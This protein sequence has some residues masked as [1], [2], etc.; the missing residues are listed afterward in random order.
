METL[1][2][3]VT[4]I[5]PSEYFLQYSYTI[6]LWNPKKGSLIKSYAG[7]HNREVLDIAIFNENDKF[8]SCGGDK[9]FYIWDVLSGKYIRKF[10]A[11]TNKIN[12][13]CLNHF[14]NVIATG[15]FDNSVK[16]WDLMSRDYRPIQVLDDFRDSITKIMITDDSIIASSVDGILRTYDIRMGKLVRDNIEAPINS[17]DIGEDKKFVAVSCLN[18]TTKLYDLST[19][20]TIADYKGHHKSDNYHGSVKFSKDN[21]YLVQASEDN[22]IVLYDIVTKEP[23]NILRGHLR[24][25]VSIDRHPVEPNKYISGS[26]DGYIKK[27]YQIFLRSMYLFFLSDFKNKILTVTLLIRT[28]KES[29]IKNFAQVEAVMRQLKVKFDGKLINQIM[30]E[31][32][33]AA[34]RLL[35][36]IKL[37]IM[38]DN[39]QEFNIQANTKTITGLDKHT[40]DRR[41]EEVMQLKTTLPTLNKFQTMNRSKK[42]ESIE[43]TL[44]K[45]EHTKKQQD[46]YAYKSQKDEE[47]LINKLYQDQRQMSMNKMKENQQ[48]MKDWEK[49][50]RKNWGQNQQKRSDAIARQ[51]YFEDL[52]VKAFK[53]KLGKEL[54]EATKD[55]AGGINEFEMNLQKLGIEKNTNIEDAIKRM[56]E[57]KGIPPGQ[58]Q[59]FSYAATMNKIKENKNLQDFAAKERDRRRRK[60]IVDQARTQN[61]LDKKKNEEQLIQ[62]IMKKQAE[63]QQFAYLEWRNQQCKQ[64]IIKNREEKAFGVEEKKKAQ[65]QELERKR[66]EEHAAMIE[67]HRKNIQDQKKYYQQ[68]RRE[69][70]LKRRMLNIEVCSE[71]MD[72]I[73]DV[74]NQTFDQQQKNGIKKLDKPTWREWMNIFV[75]NKLVSSVVGDHHHGFS[76]GLTDDD[77]TRDQYSDPLQDPTKNLE[78]ILDEMKFDPAYEDL[79]QYLS[80][81]GIFN[82]NQGD[83]APY[84]NQMLDLNSFDF[85]FKFLDSLIPPHNPE[86]GRNLKQI[87]SS[88]WQTEQ[89]DNL[90]ESKLEETIGIPHHLPLKLCIL[91]K[92][93]GGKR[94]VAK[95]I[96]EL[97]NNK[98]KVFKM[99]DLIKEVYEYVSP[100][101]QAVEV[102]KSKKAPAKKVEEAA[103]IDAYAGMDTKDYK[104]I[105]NQV[106]AIFGENFDFA[107]LN[108]SGAPDLVSMIQDDSLLIRLFIQKL[109]LSFPQDKPEQVKIEEIKL[110]I[111]KEKEILEQLA[112]LEQQNAAVGG[113]QDKKGKAPPAKGKNAGSNEDQLRQDLE[114]IQKIQ[115][116]GWILLDFPR[117]LSQA[118]LMEKLMTGFQS[119]TD[120]PKN[121]DLVAFEQWSKIASASTS[122]AD[123][124]SDLPKIYQSASDAVIFLDTPSDECFR[125]SQNRKIDP[126]TGTVYHLE[127]NP[128]P[129]NDNKL[130]DRLQEYSDPDADSNKMNNHHQVYDDNQQLLKT[131]VNGFGL[132][133][134]NIEPVNALI[135]VGITHGQKKQDVWEKVSKELQ[136]VLGFK[137]AQYDK[138]KLQVMQAEEQNQILLDQQKLLEQQQQEQLN[139]SNVIEQSPRVQNNDQNQLDASPQQQFELA[140]SRTRSQR[141]MQSQQSKRFKSEKSIVQPMTNEE[142]RDYW[143]TF[144]QSYY[145]E[146]LTVFKVIRRQRDLILEGLNDMQTRF[147]DFLQRTD[148]KVQKVHEFIESF[149]KF[150]D[151]FPDLREDEQTKEELLKRVDTLNND[152]WAIVEQRKDDAIAEHAKLIDNGWIDI[153][154]KKLIKN[155]T[156]VVQNEVNKYL[157][158]YA[159]LVG[160][161]SPMQIRVERYFNDA[162]D[163]GLAAI[164]QHKKSPILHQISKLI[165]KDIQQSLIDHQ[166]LDSDVRQQLKIESDNLIFRLNMI[167]TWITV[168]L[169]DFYYFSQEVYNTMDDWISIAVLEEN[170]AIKSVVDKLQNG[171]FEQQL[172]LDYHQFNVSA[173]DLYS[174]IQTVDYQPNKSIMLPSQ[175]G[176]TQHFKIEHLEI[177]YKDFRQYAFDR[178]LDGQTFIHII[179]LSLKENR[180]PGSWRCL[181]FSSFNNILRRYTVKPLGMDDDYS[182]PI[183]SSRD[184]DGLAQVERQFVDWKKI[185]TMFILLQTN[186][187]DDQESLNEYGEQLRELANERGEISQEDFLKAEAWFE[188]V[189]ALPDIRVEQ[190]LMGDEDDEDYDPNLMSQ[191][192]TD[193]TRLS[194]IKSLIF[195]THQNNTRKV[196]V[197]EYIHIL[198]EIQAIAYGTTCYQGLFQY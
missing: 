193:Y 147:I 81:T 47:E 76:Q 138:K 112:E 83:H 53:D 69:E 173:L 143:Q 170:N 163:S 55:M 197:N 190:Q 160:F 187:G 44:L 25:V 174:K 41:F 70:K 91:G 188:N 14:Q 123:S 125:R 87:L 181:E 88:L 92:K 82:L 80:V 75:D 110:N 152:L 130:K 52:E 43:K 105:G 154:L 120:L 145:K 24:P 9:T 128:P 129:E 103:P 124:S 175:N 16:L 6:Q 67:S 66:N 59:N 109:K 51:Q 86:L 90:E 116:E 149:N 100:K 118:K 40:L 150:S 3:Q 139:N 114:L 127:D 4:L 78:S 177:L 140:P 58:I 108:N 28:N 153:E 18:S 176:L 148:A 2:C 65:M 102:D 94:T 164:N 23:L 12:A 61:N 191:V 185:L 135:E 89:P 99:D 133:E 37:G 7:V 196:N 45:F 132:E 151:E 15:S 184:Q 21:S 157:A 68:V 156:T 57:K 29:K 136:R 115:P 73:L 56:E 38:K 182:K 194:R 142:K 189:Q 71:V 134:D 64:L 60:M 168:K 137:Q 186:M 42:L 26:A 195:N 1:L 30:N 111:Q 62:K 54:D 46:D 33:G 50:G 49:E 31:E 72:L 95:Q 107:T 106:K 141:E 126:T 113:A 74:A 27:T 96:Q 131:W 198:K 165:L 169:M 104:D 8:A 158:F 20:E 93:Y 13:I 34:L 144:E 48:F 63:E 155:A 178:Y 79:L 172:R 84:W 101:P 171:I 22:N 183:Y 17:F 167:Q 146:C 10:I 5:E 35:Y 121:Q 97:Y 11:H 180:V 179:V 122:E 117:T 19:G 98:V 36:Q 119:M 159:L 162:V 39:P 192:M 32:R 85:D 166:Q 77:P 161:E